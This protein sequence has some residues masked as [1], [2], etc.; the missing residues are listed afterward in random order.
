MTGQHCQRLREVVCIL[1]YDE[2]CG[3]N[4]DWPHTL[5]NHALVAVNTASVVSLLRTTKDPGISNTC[6]ASGPSVPGIGASILGFSF[7]TLPPQLL[8]VGDLAT[9]YSLVA[10][11]SHRFSN[12]IVPRTGVRRG[13]DRLVRRNG[14]GTQNERVRGGLEN[15]GAVRRRRRAAFLR[16]CL[17]TD[18]DRRPRR[19]DRDG[20]GSVESLRLGRA[21]KGQVE[22]GNG[23]IDCLST[24]LAASILSPKNK[25]FFL[26][27]TRR[28][29]E[30]LGVVDGQ[31]P[32]NS[33]HIL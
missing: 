6:G 25:Y 33:T 28:R 12:S 27:K 3:G 7:G 1:V 23:R 14:M 19:R 8:S 29:K 2:S 16:L 4:I 10:K 21:E 31:N 24:R 20:A 15:A 30:I 22:V 32:I 26:Y 9:S 17:R 11:R 13:L 5:L 18:H